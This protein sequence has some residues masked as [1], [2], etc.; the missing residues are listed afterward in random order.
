MPS[1]ESI[2][3]DS[4]SV[5]LFIGRSGHGKSAAAYSFPHPMIV[6]DADGRI[7]GGLTSW[8]SRKGLTYVPIL[9]RDPQNTVFDQLNREFEKL[10]GICKMSGMVETPET[11]VL[12]SA[13]WA[14]GGLLLDALPLT[15]I[16]GGDQGERGRKLGNM[17]MAGPGDYGFQSTGM[18]QIAAFLKSLPIKHIIVTAHI[19]NR[20]GRRKNENGKIIDPY[21]PSEIV[22]EQLALTDKIAESFPSI[23]DNIFRFEKVELP[24]RNKFVFSSHGE[25]ARSAYAG[26][27]F[28]N[29]DITDKS[30][31][32]TLTELIRKGDPSAGAVG[33]PATTTPTQTKIN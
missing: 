20:W 10:E 11:V 14:A 1:A 23:F 29:T 2:K 6:L 22:G 18:L 25:L 15:H 30:F 8:V 33:T 16:A 28:G 27:P 5:N 17:N 3:P 7:R 31:F 13:T 32:D 9:H 26:L 19:V 24:N 4:R 21:G 12:D